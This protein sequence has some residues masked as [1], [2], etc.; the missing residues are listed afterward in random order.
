M[1]ETYWLVE[2][3]DYREEAPLSIHPTVE[4]AKAHYPDETWE[5]YGVRERADRMD[6]VEHY[7]PG[8]W[9]TAPG[10]TVDMRIRPVDFFPD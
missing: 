6:I 4:A 3:G 5:R 8:W 7:W 2:G 9:G 1:A 10:A